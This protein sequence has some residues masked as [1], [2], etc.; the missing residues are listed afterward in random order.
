VS[1]STET[2]THRAAMEPVIDDPR[3]AV[4][5][6]ELG[7][8]GK[9]LNWRYLNSVQIAQYARL[10]A[11]YVFRQ[12]DW[13]TKASPP[14]VS[15][16]STPFNRLGLEHMETLEIAIFQL[17]SD[18]ELRAEIPPLMERLSRACPLAPASAYQIPP[19][20]TREDLLAIVAVTMRRIYRS[21][22]K[23]VVQ[24]RKRDQLL[25]FSAVST[26]AGATFSFAL[27]SYWFVTPTGIH[28]PPLLFAM[29]AGALGGFVGTFAPISQI[30]IRADAVA[31]DE[32]INTAKTALYVAP[33]SGIFFAVVI[34]FLVAGQFLMGELFP[35]M[36]TAQPDEVAKYTQN[37]PV[38]TQKEQYQARVQN[39]ERTKLLIA[40][41]YPATG[42][43]AAKLLVWCFLAGYASGFVPSALSKLV[44]NATSSIGSGSGAAGSSGDASG[45]GNPNLGSLTEASLANLSAAS[46]PTPPAETST[47]ETASDQAEAPAADSSPPAAGSA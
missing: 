45:N 36:V 9:R 3:T 8:R 24:E 13:A 18:A 34:Y 21:V 1:D 22:T 5:E 6:R 32:E 17:R 28:L 46:S 31:A 35:A 12:P 10:R 40:R 19:N 39:E 42:K 29:L 33:I 2:P 23:L 27:V 47:A 7:R 38:S 15:I 11:E 14:V 25:R 30:Q 26:L 4:D 37:Y 41:M 20:A 44:G 16:L 43:D